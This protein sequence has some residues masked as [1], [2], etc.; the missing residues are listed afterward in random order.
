MSV[1]GE[2]CVRIV[3]VCGGGMGRFS[4]REGVRQGMILKGAV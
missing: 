3:G 2:R 4:R 1:S